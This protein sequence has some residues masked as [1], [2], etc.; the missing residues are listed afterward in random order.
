M[1]DYDKTIKNMKIMTRIVCRSKKSAR[2]F[3]IDLG[4][5][6]KKGNLTKNYK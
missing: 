6:T 4:I 5:Y 3:L 2:K 1:I